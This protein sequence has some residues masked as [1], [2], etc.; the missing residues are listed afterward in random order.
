[1]GLYWDNGKWNG[2]YYLGFAV[3]DLGFRAHGLGKGVGPSGSRA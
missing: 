3:L 1:M 2:S